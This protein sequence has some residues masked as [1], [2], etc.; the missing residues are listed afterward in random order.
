MWFRPGL[1]WAAISN[2]D[3][4]GAASAFLAMQGLASVKRPTT[5]E[6][7]TYDLEPM[8][9]LSWADPQMGGPASGGFLVT[10]GFS[11]FFKGLNRLAVN[12]DRW[13]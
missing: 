13:S 10:S 7:Y 5:I 3:S 6:N 11:V 12:T 4:T 2:L 1:S 9:R 8:L